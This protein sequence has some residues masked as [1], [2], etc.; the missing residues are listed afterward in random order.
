MYKKYYILFL[1]IILPIILVLFYLLYNQLLVKKYLVQC[2]LEEWKNR[3]N[4]DIDLDKSGNYNGDFYLSTSTDTN[5]DS[6]IHLVVYQ[7]KVKQNIYIF[8]PCKNLC[9]I[10][11]K[12]NI[13]SPLYEIDVNK[14]ASEIVDEMIQ[15]NNEFIV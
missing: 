5:F 13:H 15:K 8:T 1:P 10:V 7:E 11:K 4:G 9:Y 2:I 6:H 12:N 14:S 3:T